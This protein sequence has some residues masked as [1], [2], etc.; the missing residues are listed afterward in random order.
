MTYLPIIQHFLNFFPLPEQGSLRPS[1]DGRILLSKVFIACDMLLAGIISLT[2][3]S[4][5]LGGA[6]GKSKVIPV[7]EDW[8]RAAV[9]DDPFDSQLLSE[10]VA[11]QRC[12]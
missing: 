3:T 1:F 12:R 10:W 5:S 7:D 2:K 6:Q 4:I 11:K 9:V 8:V